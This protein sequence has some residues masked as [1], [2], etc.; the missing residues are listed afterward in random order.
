MRL[1]LL[2]L[3]GA[4]GVV[5]ARDD[6]LDPLQFVNLF[7]GSV[8]GGHTFPGALCRIF[9]GVVNVRTG[10]TIPHGMVKVGMDTDSPGNASSVSASTNISHTFGF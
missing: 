4:L 6:S 2:H 7:I 9:P 8:N 3:L 1:T 5:H 10:A